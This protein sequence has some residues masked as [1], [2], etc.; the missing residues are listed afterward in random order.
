MG[1]GVVDESGVLH[2]HAAVYFG[3]MILL[4]TQAMLVSRNRTRI[5]RRV[6]W[7]GMVFGIVVAFVGLVM[8]F[9]EMQN[10]VVGGIESWPALMAHMWPSLETLTQFVVLLALGYGYRSAPEAHKRY[11]L[12]ATLALLFAATDRMFYLLGPWCA[13]IMFVLTVGPI[14]AYDLYS[15]AW[16]HAATVVG[17]LIL[18]PHFLLRAAVGY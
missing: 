5:H 4:V 14:F 3:W 2:V 8:T 16:P 10:E 17:T 1:L 7:Y 18:L 12:F 15:R 13:E 9:V 6:G 11:V